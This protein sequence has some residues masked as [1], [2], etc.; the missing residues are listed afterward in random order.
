M[1]DPECLL[2]VARAHN[3]DPVA[4]G[5]VHVRTP[6][7]RVAS[8]RLFAELDP[9]SAERIAARAE[10]GRIA[11][12]SNLWARAGERSI[13]LGYSIVV[14]T[15]ALCFRLQLTAAFVFASPH[16]ARTMRGFGFGVDCRAGNDGFFAYPDDRY[17]SCLMWA[18]PLSLARMNP[19]KT[20]EVEDLLQNDSV[21]ASSRSTASAW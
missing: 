7:N 5:R 6:Q 13:R 12:C 1:Q 15:V 10:L 21:P 4:G 3:G 17:R 9:A 20:R 8:E 2:V 18:D 19:D 14:N 11:E 16:V